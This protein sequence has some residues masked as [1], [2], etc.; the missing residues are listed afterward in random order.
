MLPRSRRPAKSTTENISKPETY[1]TG[2]KGNSRSSA[3]DSTNC[4]LNKMLCEK[5]R[6]VLEEHKT[7]RTSYN[8]EAQC[9]EHHGLELLCFIQ[10][11]LQ[12]HVRVTVYVTSSLSE[13]GSWN[14][15]INQNSH[16]RV[17][18]LIQFRC[19]G[20]TW[21]GPKYTDWKRSMEATAP[22]F[23]TNSV[24]LLV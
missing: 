7:P 16:A 22:K 15:T 14:K 24:W 1:K 18:T 3:E 4:R 20:M 10:N 2:P 17:L 9:R 6:N 5:M 21:R 8:S 19:W 13:A 23:K 12:E 11:I